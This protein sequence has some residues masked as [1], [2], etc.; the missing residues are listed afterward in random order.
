MNKQ[1]DIKRW[2]EEELFPLL[3]GGD[4]VP[5]F[6]VAEKNWATKFPQ[7]T[8]QEALQGYFN[9]KI[10]GDKLL[11]EKFIEES[12]YAEEVLVTGGL[13]ISKEALL[14]LMANFLNWKYVAPREDL[15]RYK[16]VVVGHTGENDFPPDLRIGHQFV[17]GKEGNVIDPPES[18]GLTPEQIDELPAVVPWAHTPPPEPLPF[19]IHN[20]RVDDCFEFVQKPKYKGHER[21]YKYHK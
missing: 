12:V 14:T 9:G 20:H 15:R 16:V 2:I 11:A 7:S 10:E 18:M 4:P 13:Y 5:A 3:R 8:I 21:P 1:N 6:V 19:A 17:I